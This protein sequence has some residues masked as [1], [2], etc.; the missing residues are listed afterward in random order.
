MRVGNAPGE[1]PCCPFAALFP[2]PRAGEGRPPAESCP[3]HELAPWQPGDSLPEPYPGPSVDAFFKS[4]AVETRFDIHGYAYALNL[5]VQRGLLNPRAVAAHIRDMA[6]LQRAAGARVDNRR[7]A[8]EAAQV[9]NAY[10]GIPP[11]TQEG[12]DFLE[13]QLDEYSIFRLSLLAEKRFARPKPAWVPEELT[14]PLRDDLPLG[15]NECALATFEAILAS[16]P[17]EWDAAHP[18]LPR[19]NAAA[20][21]DATHQSEDPQ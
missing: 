12:W 19:F 13:T 7:L 16:R 9:G 21:Y 5:D 15:G 17:A 3:V 6:V 18:G 1:G 11:A 20:E 14:R 10:H 4:S 8:W 2:Q